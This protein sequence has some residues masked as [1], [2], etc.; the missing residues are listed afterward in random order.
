MH[1]YEAYDAKA[2]EQNRQEYEQNLVN[3]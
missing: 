1:R 2:K 3:K